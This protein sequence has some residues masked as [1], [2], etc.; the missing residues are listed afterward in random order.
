M[1]LQ[2]KEHRDCQATS[3]AVRGKEGRSLELERECGLPASGM[4]RQHI[5]VCLRHPVLGT[6]LQQ[7]LE[8]NIVAL[9][10]Q[11]VIPLIAK[12]KLL[13]RFLVSKASSKVYRVMTA[14]GLAVFLSFIWDIFMV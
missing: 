8:T 14:G 4:V 7:P 9:F 6:L 10:S 2:A 1:C 5:S 11:K 3:E 12:H 13:E